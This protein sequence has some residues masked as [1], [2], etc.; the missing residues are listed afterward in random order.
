MQ[1]NNLNNQ[2][3]NNF[4]NQNDLN[5]MNNTPS[6]IQNQDYNNNP[7]LQNDINNQGGLNNFSDQNS[8]DNGLGNQ[9]YIDNQTNTINQVNNENEFS[10]NQDY[11]NGFYSNEKKSIWEMLKWP[12]I[13]V[14]IILVIGII[15]LFVV[16]GCSKEKPVDPEA[17]YK[18]QY[19]LISDATE[20]YLDSNKEEAPNAYG[21]C[22]QIPISKLI[23]QKYLDITTDEKLNTCDEEQTSVKVCKLESGNFQYVINFSCT[24]PDLNINYGDWL[25]GSENN[26]NDTSDVRFLF[27][28]TKTETTEAVGSAQEQIWEDEI[29][30]PS[31]TYTV[32]NT[33]TYYRYKDAMWNWTANID[34][35]Y[36]NDVTNKDTATSYYTTSPSSEYQSQGESATVYKWY[37]GSHEKYETCESTAPTGYPVQGNSC[38]NN[39]YEWFTETKI[40]YYPSG[41]ETASGE[42][43]YFKDSPVANAI[44]D[45]TTQTT[46]YKWYK[47][48]LKDFGYSKYQPV[49]GATRGEQIWS[50]WTEYSLSRPGANSSRQIE[51][52]KLITLARNAT[53]GDVTTTNITNGYVSEED[54]ITALKNA[55]YETVETLTDVMELQDI[56]YRVQ[57]YYRNT[58]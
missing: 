12:L 23:E 41:S 10:S 3:N 11:N 4:S 48:I 56:N 34:Y 19:S 24:N 25:Q 5:D 39:T 22:T 55:G 33:Q 57:M 54:L 42:Q 35:Y 9:G 8:I 38:G 37:V 47:T 29:T 45:D 40:T 13:I 16:R 1:N 51:E 14:G 36:P 20:R 58:K 2:F 7:P 30:Y 31:G 18:T 6:S 28:A 43:T 46:A 17:N 27:S 52:R 15:I 53:S 44:R 50:D 26:L 21:E 32:I 49:Y